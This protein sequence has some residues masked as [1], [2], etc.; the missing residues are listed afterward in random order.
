SDTVQATIRERGEQFAHH[1]PGKVR[2]KSVRVVPDPED[3]ARVSVRWIWV[4]PWK[5]LADDPNRETLV[6][7]P[8]VKILP[9]LNEVLTAALNRHDDP[10]PADRPIPTHVTPWIPRHRSYADPV[11]IGETEDR[12]SYYKVNYV[13][14]YGVRHGRFTA[15]TGGGKTSFI[16]AEIASAAPCRD[17]L[18]WYADVSPKGG[19]AVRAWGSV[20]DWFVTDAGELAEMLRAAEAIMLARTKAYGADGE[21]RSL[22]E[23]P[24]I[25]III[26]EANVA[27]TALEKVG[28]DLV[29]LLDPLMRT[30]RSQLVQ[31]EVIGQTGSEQGTAMR[32]YHDVMSAGDPQNGAL[33]V[34]DERALGYALNNPHAVPFDMTAAPEGVMALEP[35]G[36]DESDV[37][38]IGWIDQGDKDAT[39]PRPSLVPAIASIYAPFRP[40][41]DAPSYSAAGP[42]YHNY[43]QQQEPVDNPFLNPV[44]IAIAN[45]PVHPVRSDDDLEAN[46]DTIITARQWI[47]GIK[48]GD[49]MTFA[50]LA[51]A[52]AEEHDLGTSTEDRQARQQKLAAERAERTANVTAEFDE[53]DDRIADFAGMELPKVTYSDDDAIVTAAVEMLRQ[54]ARRGFSTA[55]L[56]AKTGKGDKAV[57]KR[58][59]FLANE[60]R[61]VKIGST[62]DT[63]WYHPDHAP[64]IETA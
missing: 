48:N 10:A 64:E 3:S 59:A 17:V 23:C 56:V 57:R 14:G 36:A 18:I 54:N 27:F 33:R 9:E 45:P 16:N 32:G 44:E 28:E 5:K 24:A 35:S 37:L 34:R 61:A 6:E 25:K 58:L 31:V 40:E 8:V 22:S 49:H 15:G 43:K 42:A 60:G 7:H 51:D 13:H 11:W 1:M 39:P 41:M 20:I 19:A 62:R 55:E 29:E 21:I 46:R 47:E 26:D 63:R 30:G 4:S 12:S 52:L 38:R 53:L 2:P 50:Q